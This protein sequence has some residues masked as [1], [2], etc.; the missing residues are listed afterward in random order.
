MSNNEVQ[1]ISYFDERFY[2]IQIAGIS[3]FMAS[4]TTKLSIESKYALNQ[5]RGLVGNREADLRM[6]EASNRGKR[7]HHAWNVFILGGVILYNPWESPIYTEAQ[8]KE[9]QVKEMVFVLKDQG[10]MVDLW[11]LQQFYEILTPKILESELIVYSIEDEIAGTL[12]NTFLIE[13]GRYKV[14]GSRDLI[15]P[16]TGIYVCDLKTGKTID[17]SYW[18]QLA[19]YKCAY[20]KM[21]DVSVEGCLIFHTGATTKSGIPGFAT[22]FKTK[23]QMKDEKHLETFFDISR[24]W[25]AR[26]PNAGP[27]AFKFPSLIKRDF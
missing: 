14:N 25:K 16:K 9:M 23:E 3:H 10:E 20:E 19:A 5:W 13:E 4:V 6:Y 21:K 2:R 27:I 22:P 15:I 7:I 11:K 1:S 26:N 8:I 24:V 18:N 17:D 12:D